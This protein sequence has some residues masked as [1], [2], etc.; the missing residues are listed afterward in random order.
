MNI[1]VGTTIKEA[2]KQLILATLEAL[3]GDKVKAADVLGVALKTLYNKL[4]AYAGRPS[5]HERNLCSTKRS[6]A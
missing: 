2:E 3:G 5:W 4:D 1:Q 6:R